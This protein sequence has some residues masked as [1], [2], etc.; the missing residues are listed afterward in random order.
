[1][2]NVEKIISKMKSQP[3]GITIEEV[4]KVLIA[5]GYS[6]LRQHGSYRSYR[7]TAGKMIVIVD[8]T[9]LKAVYVK[10]ILKHIGQ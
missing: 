4:H 3:N 8:K 7:N 10:N 1:M 5:F 6:L 2:A 9:P